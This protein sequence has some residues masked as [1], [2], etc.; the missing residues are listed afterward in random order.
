[1][2]TFLFKTIPMELEQQI[3]QTVLAKRTMNKIINEIDY[4]CIIY[5]YLDGEGSS[6]P[7]YL[8]EYNCT[9]SED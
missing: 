4:N 6:C 7:Y 8:Y 1:M 5:C 2:D 3:A 9:E